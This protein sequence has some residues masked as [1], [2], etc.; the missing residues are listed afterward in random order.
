MK[1]TRHI[2]AVEKYCHDSAYDLGREMVLLAGSFRRMLAAVETLEETR[3]CQQS[4]IA[5]AS[6]ALYEMKR[7]LN[8]LEAFLSLRK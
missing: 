7:E 8:T 1:P 2:L 6:K 3:C 4:A 5:L